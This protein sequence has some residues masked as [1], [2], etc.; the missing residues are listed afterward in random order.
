MLEKY[1]TH[2][3]HWT[4]IED[5]RTND[6]HLRKLRE[7]RWIAQY[8]FAKDFSGDMAGIYT[9]SGGRQIGKSTCFKTVMLK[10][11]ESGVRP[12]DIFYLACDTI[13]DRTDLYHVLKYFLEK[14]SERKGYLFIDE[15]TFVKEWDLTIKALADEGLFNSVV[16]CLSGS[17][18]IFIQDAVYR[19]PGRRGEAGRLDFELNPLLFHDVLSLFPDEYRGKCALDEWFRKYLTTGGYMAAVND[20]EA[21]GEI[22]LATYRVY[23]Q[24]IVG[25]FLRLNKTRRNLMQILF[26]IIKCYGSQVSFQSLSQQTEGLTK[27][28]VADYCS[29]L[30]RLGV[31]SIQHA[32][33]QN[34]LRAAPK[35]NRKVHFLDPFIASAIYRLVNDEY[36]KCPPIDE[37]LSVESVCYNYFLRKYPTYYIKA[38]GEVDIAYIDGKDFF[39]VEIKWRNQ[40]RAKD[41]KQIKKYPRAIILA[42]QEG[43][44]SIDGVKAK[45]LV[46]YLAEKQG[47]SLF[48]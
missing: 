20:L 5:F 39:P 15:V 6:P 24:W 9:L 43:E 48:P 37:S 23:Q 21:F 16:C 3:R 26:S 30:E 44:T 19:L 46:P 25:D 42:K 8:Q 32:L 41:L 40:I 11:S 7:I 29:I 12:S 2:N 31:I 10:L 18:K 14:I 27:D 1:A 35:K 4:D 36:Q 13:V 38:D 47:P 22:R 34:A 17:D 45:P 28:T 33:D